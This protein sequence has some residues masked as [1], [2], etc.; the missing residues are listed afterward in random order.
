M[1][2]HLNGAVTNCTM[3]G[4]TAASEVLPV[5]SPAQWEFVDAQSVG[6]A[7]GLPQIS[8]QGAATGTSSVANNSSTAAVLTKITSST[9]NGTSTTSTTTSASGVVPTLPTGIP[10]AT[11]SLSAP[12]SAGAIALTRHRSSRRQLSKP[13]GPSAEQRELQYAAARGCHG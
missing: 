7:I 12:P 11:S 9:G 8:K 5:T 2:T 10:A 6:L 4:D 13:R 3:N 1:A